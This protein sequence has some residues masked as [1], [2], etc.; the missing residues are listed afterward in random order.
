MVCEERERERE[1]VCVCV[2]VCA[3]VLRWNKE[4]RRGEVFPNRFILDPKKQKEL[5]KLKLT[6]AA[7]EE[8]RANAKKR[9][10]QA[11]DGICTLQ[12]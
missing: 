12:L 1:S 7:Y 9:V 3:C 11:L 6:E 8:L 5:I 4:G 10:P 2:C